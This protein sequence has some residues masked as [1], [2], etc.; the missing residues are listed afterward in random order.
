MRGKVFVVDDSLE[1]IVLLRGILTAAGYHVAS[2]QDTGLVFS[3]LFQARPDI[4]LCDVKMPG[5][6]GP[7]L[8]RML[9]RVNGDDTPILLWSGVSEGELMRHA[10]EC[11]A[12]GY[13][14]KGDPPARLLMSIE[15]TLEQRRTR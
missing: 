5:M 15:R 12:E 1:S 4:I 10:A 9:R 7:S 6:D 14:R 8:V 3:R 11:G 13:V 2:V